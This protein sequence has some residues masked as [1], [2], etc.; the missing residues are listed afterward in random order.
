[1]S[2][3]QKYILSVISGEGYSV[4]LS[5]DLE[6]VE[7]VLR[8]FNSEYFHEYN[9][10]KYKGNRVK[11]FGDWIAGLPSSFNVDFNPHTI[12]NA[13]YVI[14]LIPAT[15]TDAEQDKFVEGW[16]KLVAAEFFTLHSELNGT[17]AQSV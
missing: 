1:M 8:C 5:N 14:D 11:A 9:R 2:E 7:H 15:A 6:R 10:N 12:L 16:F 4:N 13:A 3:F 17:P